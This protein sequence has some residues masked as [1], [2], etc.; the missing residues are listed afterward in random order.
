M[1]PGLENS[2]LLCKASVALSRT[3][4]HGHYNQELQDAP[5]MGCISFLL[6]L[7][8]NCCRYAGGQG[9]SHMHLFERPRCSFWW[10]RLTTPFSEAGAALEE[11][12]S[13]LELPSRYDKV[14]VSLGGC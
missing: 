10:V 4:P 6:G 11:H 2:G 5:S 9:W 14:L 7:G 1:S 13:Q 3:I 8:W 12:L